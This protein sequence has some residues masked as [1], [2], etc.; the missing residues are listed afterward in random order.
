[1]MEFGTSIQCMDGRIQEPLIKYVKEKYN[2]RYVDTI[3]EPGPCKILS[4]NLEIS[5][6]ESV[7]RRVLISLEKHGSNIIY[8]SG[9]HDCDGNPVSKETQIKQLGK[10]EA[11]L[12]SKY[13]NI[14]IVKLWINENCNVEEI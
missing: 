4:Q 2:I 12:S 8:I 13:P 1:M 11:I 5:L 10:C 14:K 6:I 3:T 9:H 7:D